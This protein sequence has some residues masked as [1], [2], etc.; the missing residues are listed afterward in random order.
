MEVS[1][2]GP[3]R[4]VGVRAYTRLLDQ[5]LLSLEEVDRVALPGRVARLEWAVE[6]LSFKGG[7]KAV[8]APRK[9]PRLRPFGTVSTPA[10]SLVSGIKN[11]HATPEIPQF[12]SPGIV[13]RVEQIGRPVGDNGIERVEIRPLSHGSVSAVVDFETVSN[14]RQAINVSRRSW[15]SIQ[16]QLDVIKANTR[17]GPR[18]QVLIEGTRRAI[19]V[20]ASADQA[21]TLRDAWGKR[22]LVGGE[23]HR[24]VLGQAV[25]LDMTELQVLPERSATSTFDILGISPNWTGDLSTEEF[26]RQVRS[27]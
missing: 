2:D 22:V 15:G 20:R 13:E 3:R 10:L 6:D 11:L 1:I 25:R 18:A 26:M 21:N 16:G 17:S 14:A 24:N 27:V 5:V 23:L 12:F 9:V 8:I 19:T 4:A 7:L